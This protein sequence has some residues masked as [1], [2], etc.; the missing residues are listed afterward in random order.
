[1]AWPPKTAE[2]E[3]QVHAQGKVFIAQ[4]PAN[5]NLGTSVAGAP[6]ART[7][8]APG[9]RAVY[10]LAPVGVQREMAWVALN[11]ANDEANARVV[12]AIDK[13]VTPIVEATGLDKGVLGVLAKV[14]GVPLSVL[15][16]VLVVV[17]YAMLRQIGAVPSLAKV[18]K[19]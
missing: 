1:M 12:L 16:V 5:T 10:E 4:L 13:A 6:G 8:P 15:V 19:E 3:R 18:V 7:Q 14:A 17:V 9:Q 11:N 2:Y